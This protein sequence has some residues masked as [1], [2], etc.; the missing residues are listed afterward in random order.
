M[1]FV[2]LLLGLHVLEALEVTNGGL[3]LA[4]SDLLAPGGGVPVGLN[5]SLGP[6]LGTGAVAGSTPECD[7][8]VGEREALV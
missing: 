3:A 6:C 8:E 5:I 4:G 2:F 7:L 1:L